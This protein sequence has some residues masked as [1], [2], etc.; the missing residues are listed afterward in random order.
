[1]HQAD[2]EIPD[3]DA[4]AA[5]AE[6]VMKSTA[7]PVTLEAQIVCVMRELG[8][9]RRVY[10]RLVEQRRMTIATAGKELDAMLAVLQTLEALHDS[11]GTQISFTFT[12]DDTM[13][14][15]TKT[16]EE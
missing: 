8:L 10:P 1:M 13:G 2:H 5:A 3:D 16:W 4:I 7:P 14:C 6:Y 9:R 11:R 12:A 15:I